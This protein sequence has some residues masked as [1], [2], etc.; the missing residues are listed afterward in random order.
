MKQQTQSYYEHK[1][2]RYGLPAVLFL[3]ALAGFLQTVQRTT[4]FWDCGEFIA[5][6]YI[7]GILSLSQRPITPLRPIL[8]FSQ[9]CAIV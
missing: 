2:I 4:S 1:A 8:Y 6:S 3:L 5:T 9:I 7:L